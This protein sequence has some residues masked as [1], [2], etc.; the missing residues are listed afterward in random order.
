MKTNEL[1]KV[2]KPLIKQ[3]IKEVI[4]E[5]GVLSG[6]IGEV[7]KGVN[8]APIIKEEVKKSEPMF[9]VKDRRKSKNIMLEEQRKKI[10][11]S[12]GKD[13]FNGVNIFEDVT[14]AP[15]EGAANQHSPLANL[16]PEDPGVDISGLLKN[17]WS[18]LV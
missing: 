12:I 1:K 6:I 7:M 3:C 16:S 18:N 15:S 17:N 14:P 2:L 11:D 8:T 9:N 13:S 5:D 4:F 10:L